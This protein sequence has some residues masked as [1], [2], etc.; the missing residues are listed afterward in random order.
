MITNYVHE[1]KN[2]LLTH[3]NIKSWKTISEEITFLTLFI[4]IE[5]ELFDDSKLYI[6]EYHVF[7]DNKLS[8]RKYSYH[9]QD[10]NNKIIRWDN[11]KHH[12]EIPTFPHHIHIDNEVKASKEI[13]LNEVLNFIIK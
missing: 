10:I 6:F 9:W 1:L 7:E 8:K 2:I 4:R 3:P 12:K 13:N 11:A 5:A